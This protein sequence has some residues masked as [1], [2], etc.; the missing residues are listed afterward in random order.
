MKVTVRTDFDID[1][2]GNVLELEPPVTLKE[3]LENISAKFHFPIIDPKT[4]KLD[5]F[6]QVNVNDRDCYVLPQQ[7]DTPLQDG[8]VVEVL[9][10]VMVAG[11]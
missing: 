4:G 7:L 5:Y 3:V 9:L 10:A 6:L 2:D 11:G 1:R 8:D